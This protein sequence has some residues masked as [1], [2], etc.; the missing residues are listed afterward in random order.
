MKN[1]KTYIVIAAIVG[2]SIG[3]YFVFKGIKKKKENIEDNDSQTGS[4]G[5]GNIGNTNTGKPPTSTGNKRAIV[6]DGVN[7]RVSPSTNGKIIRIAKKGE[8][9]TILD[10]S[11]TW[12]KISEGWITAK[13]EFVRTENN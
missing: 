10:K 6:I 8:S 5:V 11:G 3:A 2:L 9:F 12:Y 4:T 7:V 1:K 13:P